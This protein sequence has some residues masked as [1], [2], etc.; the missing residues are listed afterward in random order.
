MGD[1]ADAPADAGRGGEAGA[2][3]SPTGEMSTAS[4]VSPRRASHTATA[5]R[6]QATSSARPDRA[7]RDQLGGTCQGAGWG[8]AGGP[9]APCRASHRAR[10]PPLT[11][12]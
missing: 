1:P 5:P 4:T 10:S 6:P 8:G 2:G 7:G 9:A 11:A 12:A 3:A